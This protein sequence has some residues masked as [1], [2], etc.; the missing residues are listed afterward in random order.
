MLAGATG[1]L[2]AA[3]SP[4]DLAR[5]SLAFT[6]TNATLTALLGIGLAGVG[7]LVLRLRRFGYQG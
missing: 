2:A 4:G 1:L 5:G 7:A 6:G 3:A